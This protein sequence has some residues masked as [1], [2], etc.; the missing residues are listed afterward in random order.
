[1]TVCPGVRG[2][3]EVQPLVR[4]M[5]LS[6]AVDGLRQVFIRGADMG[7]GA[8]QVDLIVLAAIAVLF[9]TVAS[10][11]IRRNVA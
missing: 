3:G 2:C 6:Y 10:L 11:T 7:V 9:G 8:L 4:I 5:P 1:M